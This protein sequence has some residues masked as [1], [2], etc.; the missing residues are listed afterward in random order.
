LFA[1]RG[2]EGGAEALTVREIM[3]PRP[4]AVGPDTPTLEAVR[5][6]RSRRVG[7]LP[8]VE[9]GL[10]IGI[11]TAQDFLEISS[12]LFEERERAGEATART[13]TSGPARERD[14]PVTAPGVGDLPPAGAPA[15]MASATG[16]RA[17]EA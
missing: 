17:A 3:K 5:I 15:P 16:A 9:N 11:V 6:M 2:A 1:R 12:R 7:C 10:L 8:V 13:Q 4:V 14:R